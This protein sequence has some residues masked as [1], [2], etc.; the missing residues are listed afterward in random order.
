MTARVIQIEEFRLTRALRT[1]TAKDCAHMKLTM[2]SAGAG[3]VTCDD[4]HMQVSAFWA[5]QTM[6]EHYQRAMEKLAH[7]EN[8]QSERESKTIHLKAA[9]AAES[10]WR[11]RTTVPTCPSCSQPIFASD[12]FGRGFV[13]KETAERMRTELRIRKQNEIDARNASADKINSATDAEGFP[14]ND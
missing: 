10:A 2:D 6:S 5:L 1:Y 12:G 3:I 4:C 14:K 7:R 11:S 8:S 9:Q 13:S